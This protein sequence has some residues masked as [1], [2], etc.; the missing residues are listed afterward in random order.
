[1]TKRLL[2]GAVALLLVIASAYASFYIAPEERTMGVIQRIF[3]FHVASA[4]AGFSAFF[5]LLRFQPALR[6]ASRS[7][8]RLARRFFR[9]SR[10]RLHHHRSDH[11]PDLGASRLGHL[12]DLGR[13]PHLHLHPL[14]ALRFLSAPP[15]SGGR[16]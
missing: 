2:L 15:H 9:G 6:L 13:A 8:I 5:D 1:M 3:Y 16:A 14:A 12:V 11:W 4:W 7:E 10:P